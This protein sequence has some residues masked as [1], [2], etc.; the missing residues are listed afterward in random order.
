MNKWKINL[1]RKSIY[2]GIKIQILRN[3]CNK[4][5]LPTVHGRRRRPTGGRG[6]P[7]TG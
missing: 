2:C 6:F 5:K 1:I 7:S 4:R 3:R